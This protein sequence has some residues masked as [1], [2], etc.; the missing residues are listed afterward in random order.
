MYD[1]HRHRTK[2]TVRPRTVPRRVK[3][4]A[5]RAYERRL[6]RTVSDST[7]CSTCDVQTDDGSAWYREWVQQADCVRYGYGCY[8][9]STLPTKDLSDA[10]KV[11]LWCGATVVVTRMPGAQSFMHLGSARSKCFWGAVGYFSWIWGN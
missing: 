8:P 10:E 4:M 7:P 1:K 5:I 9:T 2:D 11:I 6:A 3:R